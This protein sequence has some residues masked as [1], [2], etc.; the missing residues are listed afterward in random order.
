MPV[1]PRT[2]VLVGY[3]QVNHRDE[4]DPATR[5]VEPVDLMVAAA[6]QA[7]DSRVLE[8]VD[9]V[10]VV[11]VLSAHY[12]D[13]ALLLGAAHR[14]RR[15]HHAV[16][17][18][19]RQRA[20]V[21]GQPGVPGYPAGP[22]RAWCCLPA[23]KPGAPAGA[24]SQGR[25][26]RVDGAGRVR[27]GWPRSPATDVPMA[28]DAEIRIRLDRPAYVYPLFEQALRIANGESVED[29]GKRVGELWARF[30]AVAVG[31]P[32]AWIRKP[33]TAE[34]ITPAGPAEPDDQLALHQADELQ[35][36][37]RPGRRADPDLGRAG[38]PP[39]DPRRTLGL[40]ARGHRRA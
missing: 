3:G 13:P 28:G 39:A 40:S 6:R 15:L 26:T 36:H 12:R 9:S 11:N 17:P 30:N 7:A 34:E 25:Q 16:Q 5:S 19:R 1:D 33:A 8:A 21:A 29:H 31:N 20:A 37:G 35:Q 4:I 14:R 38:Q 24:E 27:A 32:H 2:P 10:R 22:G 18:G 23:P